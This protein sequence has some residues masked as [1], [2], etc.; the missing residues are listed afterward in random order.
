VTNYHTNII[1]VNGQLTTIGE[2]VLDE[3]LVR[4]TLNGFSKTWTPFIKIIVAQKTLP[5]F[6]MIWDDFI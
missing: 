1:Q 4:M 6:D 5:K 3:E 2:V